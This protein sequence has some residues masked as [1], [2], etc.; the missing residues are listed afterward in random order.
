MR[1]VYKS[2]DMLSFADVQELEVCS[3]AAEEDLGNRA[4]LF[5]EHALHPQDLN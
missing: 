4:E 2:K 1:H 3:A 5:N